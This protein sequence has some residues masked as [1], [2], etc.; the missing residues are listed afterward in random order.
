PVKW[1]DVKA[2]VDADG[3]KVK[4]VKVSVFFSAYDKVND[5][6]TKDELKKVEQKTDEAAKTAD[7]AADKGTANTDAI[8]RL[9]GDV[10]KL[11]EDVNKTVGEQVDKLQ[12]AVD[13]VG[14]RVEELA[15]Q[16]G[17][18][19]DRV[20][21]VEQ[22][23]DEA[24]KRSN[25]AAGQADEA[26]KAADDAAGAAGDA[27]KQAGAIDSRVKD[28]ET[29]VNAKLDSLAGEGAGATAQPAAGA[30][31]LDALDG[32]IGDLRSEAIAADKKRAVTV[33]DQLTALRGEIDQLKQSRATAGADEGVVRRVSQDAGPYPAPDL[34]IPAVNLS[35]ATGVGSQIQGSTTGRSVALGDLQPLEVDD[36]S[37]TTAK[38][39]DG[40]VTSAKFK[41]GRVDYR[42]EAGAD[43]EVGGGG[44]FTDVEGA[45]AAGAAGG[46]YRYRSGK[47]D[48]V[49]L[50]NGRLM[51]KGSDPDK[52]IGVRIVAVIDGK[53]KVCG[54]SFEYGTDWSTIAVPC[55]IEIPAGKDVIIKWQVRSEEGGTA[56][57]FRKSATTAPYVN[58][59]ASAR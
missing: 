55:S 13:E 45:G 16:V 30:D 28:L 36:G 54:E 40:A 52:G 37:V 23:A 4:H 59:F 21:G 22:K 1:D 42:V 7:A 34:T 49:L 3:R 33:D 18:L 29:K 8:A 50:L 6:V 51:A 35:A 31:E 38:L 44:E 10:D 12:G 43:V 57:V 17:D 15:G 39:A 32:K 20:T 53:E 41:P 5:A 11:V 2:T 26:A 56:F 58:G 19:A 14:K 9:T 24:A 27:S 46:G 48:E 47:S 25:E